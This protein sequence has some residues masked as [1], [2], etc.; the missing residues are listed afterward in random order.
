LAGATLEEFYYERIINPIVIADIAVKINIP[1]RGLY[2]IQANAKTNKKITE[3]IISAIIKI[4]NPKTD[5][6]NEPAKGIHE[7]NDM[8]GEKKK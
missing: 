1:K 2:R 8:I 6:S 4:T 5:P 3:P 7:T